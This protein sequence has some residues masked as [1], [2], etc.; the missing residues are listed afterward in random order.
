MLMLHRYA[1]FSLTADTL[2]DRNGNI[3]PVQ[4]QAEVSLISSL[5]RPGTGWLFV[6]VDFIISYN[7]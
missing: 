1:I 4:I 6:T 5:I 2:Y 7:Y 3:L